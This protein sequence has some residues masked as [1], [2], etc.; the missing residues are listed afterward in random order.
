M[1]MITGLTRGGTSWTPEF[2]FE[3]D[4]TKCL[5][6][7]RCYKV[8]P[9]DVFDLVENDSD[10]LDDDFDDE[11]LMMMTLKDVLDCIGCVAC[12]RVC[13]KGCLSHSSAPLPA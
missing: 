13:P 3:L 1:S 11:V 6:C 12:S 5:G 10:D 9:R 8:C 4:E 7:G 2:V